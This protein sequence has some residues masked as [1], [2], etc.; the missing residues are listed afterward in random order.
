MS[1]PVILINFNRLTTT[2]RL[3]DQLLMLGYDNLYILDMGSTYPPLLEWYD[4]CKSITVIY[5]E[6]RGH[7][8][9]WTDGILK[10]YFREDAWVAVSDS[11]IEL[12][13]TTPKGFIEDMVCIAKD[14]RQDKVGLALDIS[15]ITNQYLKNIIDPIERV[16]WQHRLPHIT[17]EVYNAPVDT[18]MCVVQPLKDFSYRALRLGGIYTCKHTDW[19]IDWE[20]L[21]EEQE[22]YYEHANEVVATGKR[23]WLNWKKEHGR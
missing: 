17:Y 19:Y 23:H 3:V 7:K 1:I 13:H 12:A 5:H 11:D 14:F 9:L 18:T 16:Y 20:H 10:D 22:Y 4:Q 8:A 2:M 15:N 21:T 6:N